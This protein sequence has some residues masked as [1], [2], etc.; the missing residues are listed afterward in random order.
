MENIE[1]LKT[2]ATRF[3]HMIRAYYN[4]FSLADNKPT[5]RKVLDDLD[6]EGL[7]IRD[8]I[9]YSTPGRY[10]GAYRSLKQEYCYKEPTRIA[11]LDAIES[12]YKQGLDDNHR[13]EKLEMFTKPAIV[14]KSSLGSAF[15][16]GLASALCPERFMIYN[17]ISASFLSE[18]NTYE[19]ITHRHIGNYRHF[20]ELH[21]KIAK[22]IKKPLVELDAMWWNE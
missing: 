18:Y 17:K 5:L 20:N 8:I 1:E 13:Y 15:L 14:G 21:Q 12:F 10:K 22:R 16:S 11:L 4:I 6:L 7:L 2:N 3:R 19:Y 9:K